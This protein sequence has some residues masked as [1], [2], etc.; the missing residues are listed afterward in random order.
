MVDRGWHPVLPMVSELP[1]RAAHRTTPSESR[2]GLALRA[3]PRRACPGQRRSRL[4][5]QL[6]RL[7]SNC[8]GLLPPATA[9]AAQ[10]RGMHTATGRS[11]VA[12]SQG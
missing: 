8:A 11:L 5:T 2:S 3:A 4:G 1:P 7:M 10:L 12:L 9:A 6:P